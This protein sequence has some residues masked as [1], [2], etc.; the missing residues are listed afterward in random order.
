LVRRL[1]PAGE[2]R[3]VFPDRR[4]RRAFGFPDLALLLVEVVGEALLEYVVQGVGDGGEMRA[5]FTEAL[6]D[7]LD[8]GEVQID[9]F[10]FK[11]VV[12]DG[13]RV[14]PGLESILG[15]QRLDAIV[16]LGDI[17]GD[18]EIRGIEL[19]AWL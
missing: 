8:P 9:S 5:G 19:E 6:G 2:A 14:G 18:R 4:C 17:G 13:Q 15:A 12:G 16:G 7:E 3:S 1:A 10:A 11:L